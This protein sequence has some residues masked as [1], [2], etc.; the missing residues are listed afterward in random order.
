LFS[1]I[2]FIVALVAVLVTGCTNSP[3]WVSVGNDIIDL[4]NQS[5][6]FVK[7]IPYRLFDIQTKSEVIKKTTDIVD[8]ILAIQAGRAQGELVI[9]AVHSC[10]APD[11]RH[12]LPT[13]LC[14]SQ[15]RGDVYLAGDEK[16]RSKLLHLVEGKQV[17]NAMGKV[18][19]LHAGAPVILVI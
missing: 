10:W 16:V 8:L 1:K 15:S 13:V 14:S 3:E 4:E 11:V 19:G 12:G 2:I 9:I 5:P 18:L 7:Q 17:G 6:A